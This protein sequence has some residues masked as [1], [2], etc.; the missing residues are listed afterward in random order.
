MV[1]AMRHIEHA[2]RDRRPL[3]MRVRPPL[4][5]RLG[6]L[7]VPIAGFEGGNLAT[8]LLILRAT[9]L[10]TPGAG[11]DQATRT[12]LLPYAGHNIAAAL[13]SIPAGRAADR[14]GYSSSLSGRHRPT[15]LRWV[16]GC[17]GTHGRPSNDGLGGRPLR[18]P[19]S[20]GIYS[21]GRQLI[22]KGR[23]FRSF[24]LGSPGFLDP[25]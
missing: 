7:W 3:R 15:A 2:D 6:R 4:Q 13:V 9:E 10:L 20:P 25:A 5:G 22:P 8:T 19:R 14:W 17:C 23:R 12:A 16:R 18:P 21:K 1:Y 24:P 11:V